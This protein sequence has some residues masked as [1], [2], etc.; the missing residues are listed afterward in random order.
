MG[1]SRWK[2]TVSDAFFLEMVRFPID[3]IFSLDSPAIESFQTKK[4]STTGKSDRGGIY[5]HFEVLGE[6][7]GSVRS[8]NLS[9]SLGT[10]STL[11][12]LT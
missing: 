11:S 3:L 7:D 1:S 10:F 5:A 8:Y 9:Y 2:S 4:F 6:K 12:P